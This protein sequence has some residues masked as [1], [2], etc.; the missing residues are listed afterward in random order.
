MSIFLAIAFVAFIIYL[1]LP[2][3]SIV[4]IHIRL[5]DQHGNSINENASA[6]FFYE[7]KEKYAEVSFKELPAWNRD[8]L[9][10]KLI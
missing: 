4:S 5:Q 8:D 2:L 6:I 9:F 7:N 10:Q 3:D 1:I